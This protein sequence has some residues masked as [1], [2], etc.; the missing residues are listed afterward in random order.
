ML[1]YSGGDTANQG[2]GAGAS[3]HYLDR[4]GSVVVDIL[5]H[6]LAQV[7]SEEIK[8]LLGNIAGQNDSIGVAEVYRKWRNL[9]NRLGQMVTDP[10]GVGVSAGQGSAPVGDDS[11]RKIVGGDSPAQGGLGAGG[12]I[13]PDSAG[14]GRAGDQRLEAAAM[15]A[16]AERAVGVDDNVTKFSGASS[17]A[18][19]QAAVDDHVA[20][21]AIAD[22]EI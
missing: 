22:V 17:G 15:A 1:H 7:L 4:A 14:Q 2:V 11:F 19:D 21:D 13:L 5:F 9:T 10:Q 18:V 20:A 3:G 8:T 16:S 6:A 12:D